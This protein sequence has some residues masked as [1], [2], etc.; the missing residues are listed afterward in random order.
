MAAGFPEQLSTVRANPIADPAP[1][2]A[3]QET[4]SRMMRSRYGFGL[5]AAFRCRFLEVRHS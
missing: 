3:R 5:S 1:G 2:V 4:T